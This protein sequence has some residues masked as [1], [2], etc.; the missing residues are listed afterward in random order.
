M[1][2]TTC[3]GGK[4]WEPSRANNGADWMDL[5]R[6]SLH[7]GSSIGGARSLACQIMGMRFS[8]AAGLFHDL[9][10]PVSS[11]LGPRCVVLRLGRR[12]ET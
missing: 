3:R 12:D 10:H 11:P 9:P 2:G 6:T 5:G 1:G 8:T 4:G 7:G